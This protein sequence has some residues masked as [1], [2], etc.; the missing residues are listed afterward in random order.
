M[1]YVLWSLVPFTASSLSCLHKKITPTFSSISPKHNSTVSGASRLPYG[2]QK[3]RS[4]NSNESQVGLQSDTSNNHNR[5]SW[6][7]FRNTSTS[8]PQQRNERE[9]SSIREAVTSPVC[10][11][12]SPA[13]S[14]TTGIQES[15]RARRDSVNRQQ[16]AL[17]RVL[18]PDEA[19]VLERANQIVMYVMFLFMVGAV[20]KEGVHIA[21]C[22]GGRIGWNINVTKNA[23]QLFCFEYGRMTHLQLKSNWYT[24]TIK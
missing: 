9:F 8:S 11:N 19:K 20:V 22:I 7:Q 6:P 17:E 12:V 4:I 3:Q 1:P 16:G 2:Y 23:I 15:A 5:L 13:I 10:D 14:V 18:C 24:F 21:A